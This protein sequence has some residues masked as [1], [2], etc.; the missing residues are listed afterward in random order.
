VTIKE[1]AFA[2]LRSALPELKRQWP[3]KSLGVFGSFARD[4]ARDESDIDILVEFDQPIGLFEFFRLEEALEKIMGRRVDLATRA[5]LKPFMAQNIMR[6]L[7]M[8]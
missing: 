8:L 6:D 4:D 5:A 3:I 1:A 7:V 2:K